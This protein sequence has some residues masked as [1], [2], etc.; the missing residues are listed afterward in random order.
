[1]GNKSIEVQFARNIEPRNT[2]VKYRFYC[3]RKLDFFVCHKVVP[4]ER[5]HVERVAKKYFKGPAAKKRELARRHKE[6]LLQKAILGQAN[7]P[8]AI[9]EL[10][11]AKKEEIALYQKG[12]HPKQIHAAFEKWGDAA[13]D[14]I[15]EDP[16]VLNELKGIAF[17]TADR[18]ARLLDNR[19]D[20]A[21]RAPEFK[22][23]LKELLNNRGDSLFA[24]AEFF[25]LRKLFEIRQD[26]FEEDWLRI[27]L[28][29]KRWYSPKEW[30]RME[31][32]VCQWLAKASDDNKITVITGGPGTGK[33]Y[34]LQKTL[35]KKCTILTPTG[36]AAMR[37]IE[38]GHDRAKTIHRWIGWPPKP[39][40]KHKLKHVQLLGVDEGSMV[41]IEVLY[42]LLKTLDYDTLQRLIIA[43]DHNQLPSVG[44][45]Q[46]LKDMVRWLPNDRIIHLVNPHRFVST[47]GQKC[48]EIVEGK[49]PAWNNDLQF[50][51]ANDSREFVAAMKE[52]G[53][54]QVISPRATI[55]VFGTRSLNPRLRKLWLNTEAPFTVGEPVIQ[56]KND[57]EL[58]VFN[59]EI[60]KVVQR[61]ADKIVVEFPDKDVI[62]YPTDY[63]HLHPAYVITVHKSQGSEWD[64]VVIAV[65]PSMGAF[66]NRN[67]IYTAVSRAKRKCWIV[68]SKKAWKTA[69]ERPGRKR[70]LAFGALLGEALYGKK[71]SSV[72]MEE[73]VPEE[74]LF[75]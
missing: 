54:K 7:Q 59:G 48:A 40:D 67:L 62:E 42:H 44:R 50:I 31:E 55:S 9:I 70:K 60:G 53:Q 57:Y 58:K 10:L 22:G 21:I 69:I 47:I 16:Y 39:N 37:I 17:P 34:L 25:E 66:L 51:P 49:I 75:V 68:G 52:L 74:E 13:P 19:T 24:A 46:V 11:K 18:L 26:F 43:G 35:P 38:I 6:K 23:Y 41:D 45:G 33:S 64:E 30:I 8:E 71:V 1:M 61:T 27:F 32:F 63:K 14:L 5:D 4:L 73:I 20:D 28:G 2:I 15:R 36:K 65:E 72:H 12:L 56:T 29:K 3:K